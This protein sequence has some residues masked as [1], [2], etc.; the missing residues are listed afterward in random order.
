MKFEQDF[1]KQFIIPVIRHTQEEDLYSLC[2]AL[3]D[4]GLTI[5]EV[6]L[7]SEAALK[8]IKKLS[9]ESGLIIGA[10]TVL[11]ETQVEKAIAAGAKF[12]VSPGLHEDS[13]KK[14]LSHN[15]PFIPGVLSPS[16]IM[17]AL[18]LGCDMVKLF[19]ASSVGGPAYIKTLKG[20]FPEMNWMVTGGI[21]FDEIPFYRKA[22]VNC[23][24]LGSNLTSAELIEQK[25]WKEI[26]K[27]TKD[28]L[29]KL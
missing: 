13:V 14:A 29:G 17:H 7:M 12:L 8:V 6:T 15:T 21:S 10:G 2:S 9:A 20:P 25:N 18:S 3:I 4:G 16:E 19:P 22:G 1:H 28:F 26:T 27:L 24:G 11:N 23:I 5:L